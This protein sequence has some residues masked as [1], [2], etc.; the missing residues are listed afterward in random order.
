MYNAVNIA[1]AKNRQ[2]FRK[3]SKKICNP[4]TKH[5]L[6]GLAKHPLMESE[7]KFLGQ[8]YGIAPKL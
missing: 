1:F 4:G 6:Q 3:K 8:K 7:Q 2:V 5:T